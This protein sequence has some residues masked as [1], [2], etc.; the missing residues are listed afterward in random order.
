LS[1]PTARRSALHDGPPR[2]D[3]LQAK[4]EAIRAAQV[5]TQKEPDALMQSVLEKAFRGEL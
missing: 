1:T 4:A 3:G 5:E 2:V